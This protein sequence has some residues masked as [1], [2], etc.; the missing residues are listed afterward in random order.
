MTFPLILHIPSLLPLLSFKLAVSRTL[1]EE[2]DG[3]LEKLLENGWQIIPPEEASGDHL[4]YQKFIYSSVGEISVAKETYVKANTGWFS[5]RSACY[6]AAGRPVVA[7]DTG[8]SEFY[9]TGLGLFSFSDENEAVQAIQEISGNWKAH[10]MGAKELAEAY[11][12]HK[13]V[14]GKLIDSL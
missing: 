6:L 9:P 2:E 13:I 4:L 5:C 3:Q 14:L 1:V 12:D 10:S 7:Q 11:F 8:W